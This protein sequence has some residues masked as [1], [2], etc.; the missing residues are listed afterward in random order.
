ME[1]FLSSEKE[2]TATKEGGVRKRPWDESISGILRKTREKV[3]GS[4]WKE[5]GGVRLHFLRGRKGDR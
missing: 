1:A 4:Y 2:D 5:A 3:P